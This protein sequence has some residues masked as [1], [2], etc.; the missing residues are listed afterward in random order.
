VKG[1][2]GF[3]GAFFGPGMEQQQLTFKYKKSLK[4]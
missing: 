3:I 2:K 4:R 1:G